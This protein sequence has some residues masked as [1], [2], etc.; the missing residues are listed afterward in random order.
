MAR[1]SAILKTAP[2]QVLDAKNFSQ[3][4]S[5]VCACRFSVGMTMFGLVELLSVGI[6]HPRFAHEQLINGSG[7]K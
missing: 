5:N 7:L 3:S 1:R 2:V 6:Y 4:R